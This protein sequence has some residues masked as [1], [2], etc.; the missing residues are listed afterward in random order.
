MAEP[1]LEPPM[2]DD[3]EDLLAL[4]LQRCAAEPIHL[5]GAIQIHGVFL[6]FDHAGI[7]RMASDNLHTLLECSAQ[8]ALGRPVADLLEKDASAYLLAR[9][10]ETEAGASVQLNFRTAGSGTR[11]LSARAHRAGELIVVEL[12]TEA[13]STTSEAKATIALLG[14]SLRQAD[15]HGDIESYCG[16]VASMLRE[17][18]HFDRVKVYRFDSHFHGDVIAE[19]RNDVLPSLLH[20]H[21]PASDIPPQARALYEKNLVRILFDADALTVPVIPVLNPQTGLPIDMS[22][23]M[24]R[25][26]SPVHIEYLRNMGVRSTITISL[27]HEGR[28]WGLVACHSAMPQRVSSGLRETIELVGKTIA[29][30]IGAL[31]NAMRLQAMNDVRSHLQRL[32]ERIRVA[33]DFDTAVRHSKA[34][35]LGLTDACGCYVH[36]KGHDVWIGDI[37][38]AGKLQALVAWVKQQDRTDGV[39]VTD[40]LGS[41]YPPARDFA[42]RASGLLA[43]ML[44]NENRDFILWFRPEVQRNI[45]WA[46]NPN[47]RVTTDELGPRIDPRRSFAVWLE[48]ARGYSDPWLNTTIDAVKLFSLSVVQILMQQTR[49]QALVAE[50]ANAAKSEFLS[51]M[52][53]ELRTPLNAILGFAQMLALPG[54]SSLTEQ[55]ADNVQEILK[56]GQY[57][58]V[59]INEVLDLARIESGRIELS[60]EPL[61]LEP[62]IKDCIA[63]VQP[64]AAARGIAIA[65]QLDE[66][67]ALQ[68]DYT[69]VTQVL[70]NLLSNAIKYNRDGGQIHVVVVP[71]GECL[72]I[73]VRD[74][75]R[76]I[77]PDKQERLFKPFERLESSY[78]GI[79]GTGIGLALVKRL[80]E[81]MGGEIGVDSE[82]GVGSTFWFVLPAATLPSLPETAPSKVG[83]GGTAPAV[84]V[85]PTSA[86]SPRRV[87]YIEDNPANLKLIR[88]IISLRPE[89]ALL[90]AINA[91]LG[92]E[93]ARRERPDLILL[94]INL[95]GMDGF[96]ALAMCRGFLELSGSV[97][98]ELSAFSVEGGKRRRA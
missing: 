3:R 85:V 48:A 4:A 61:P 43:V 19:S 76:G 8:D 82:E 10:S 70:L 79:E 62:L 14:E 63:Q 30:K 51:R 45:R 25:A 66:A 36:Y 84:T 13:P 86:Q 47:G 95:P 17:L 1:G 96:A 24:L 34:E 80:V 68:G 11:E 60:L 90:D 78:D 65:A 42:D 77:A 49:K 56:A 35:V 57:L 89:F 27:L 31:V 97:V 94:D 58:L 5:A 88:K 2:S 26:I 16:Y 41:L 74:T 21:F 73:E 29:M 22:H 93:I 64:L 28:L 9:L 81:A 20:H 23:A 52:S 75:G 40:Q 69:R 98:F 33:D 50:R 12:E 59:Q 44:D 46:G 39:F 18:T 87:L 15:R 67:M 53:H 7:V 6:A 38:A 83:A 32:T 71:D 37:P 91:E 54:K 72:R 55:Q 92:L